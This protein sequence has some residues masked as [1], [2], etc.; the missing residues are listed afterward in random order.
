MNVNVSV[1]IPTL[2]E[3]GNI[4]EVLKGVF[5]YANEVIIVDGYSKDNTV[6]IAQEFP[7]KILYD[8]IGKGSALRKGFAAAKGEIIVM[9]DCDLSH[10]PSEIKQAINVVGEGYDICMPS[11]F[12]G[13]SDD[14]TK[15]RRFLNIVLTTIVNVAWKTNYTDVC[16]GFRVMKKDALQALNLTSD[17][18]EIETELSIKAAK[19]HLKTKEIP[20]YEKKREHGKSKFNLLFDGMRIINRVIKELISIK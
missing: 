19:K 20:T 2:N 8:N 7:V 1:V 4:R 3:E 16:Y 18:F 5:Q 12:I 15:F 14:F 13:K 11:R 9:F 17:G 6:S 10:R